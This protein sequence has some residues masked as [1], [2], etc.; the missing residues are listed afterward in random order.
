MS[1]FECA[2]QGIIF[3]AVIILL[4]QFFVKPMYQSKKHCDGMTDN[5]KYTVKSCGKK[6]GTPG[7]E[8]IIIPDSGNYSGD[9]VQKMSLESEI[10]K[11]QSDYINGLGFSG[12]P[13]G[14]S[15]ETVLEETGRS[16]GTADFVG[17][18][19][20]KFCKARQMATPAEDARTVPTE[21][22][23]EWCNIDMM[24]LV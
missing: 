9:T 1:N 5:N 2:L 12:L 7:Y 16:Y 3:V 17:L 6:I 23:K 4:W 21:T 15:H 11:S 18:T 19:A 14:S 8:P 24:E 20:R 22:I 13:T 10:Y